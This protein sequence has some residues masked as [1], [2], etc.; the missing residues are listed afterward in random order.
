MSGVAGNTADRPRVESGRKQ[1]HEQRSPNGNMLATLGDGLKFSLGCFRE[2]IYAIVHYPTE[3]VRQSGI[4]VLSSS[5]VI[6]LQLAAL[7][8]EVPTFAYSLLQG[9]G[10]TAYLGVATGLV[11]LYGVG[12]VCY[13][14]IIAAKI[15]CGFVA[16][17]GSMRI[18]EEID[19][20][21]VMGIRPKAFL[22]GTR[23]A[24]YILTFPFTFILG[25]AFMYGSSWIVATMLNAVSNGGYWDQFWLMQT[26]FQLVLV[27]VWALTMGVSLLLVG[28]YY[29]YNASGGPVGVGQSTAKSM[30]VN[31]I[32][33]GVVSVVLFQGL[34]GSSMQVPFGN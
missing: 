10:A 31:L 1:D 19:A 27:C 30:F 20:L 34:F 32:V 29:G 18:T 17:L 4:L 13:S 2:I 24:A 23:L 33:S 28:C 8:A 6:W 21:T 11:D 16:E 25:I 22:V 15:A 12:V 7:G 26:P 3:V 14:Y 9:V 5:A